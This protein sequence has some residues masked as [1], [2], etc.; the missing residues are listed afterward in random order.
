MGGLNVVSEKS[1]VQDFRNPVRVS[2]MLDAVGGLEGSGRPSKGSQRRNATDRSVLERQLARHSPATDDGARGEAPVEVRPFANLCRICERP[3][4]AVITGCGVVAS[5]GVGYDAF[6]SALAEG[7]SGIGE[8][9]SFDPS[10]TGRERAAEIPDFDEGEFLRSPKNYLDRSSALAFAACEMAV[11]QSGVSLPN[12]DAGHGVSVGSVSGNVESLSLFWNKV[13]EKGPK[14]APPFLFPHTYYNTTAGLLSIEYG[15][16]GPHQQFCSG[17]AGLEAVL[18]ASQCVE[19]RRA[20]L[21][22]AGGVEAFS[23]WLFRAALGRGWLSPRD[24]GAESCR[25]FG[26]KRNGTILGE[27]TA[28]FAIEPLHAAQQRGARILARVRGCGI[29]PSPR[30]AMSQALA[31]AAL[32]PGNV[33]AVFASAGGYVNED[34]REAQ[35]IKETFAGRPVP[36]VAIKGLTGETLGASGALNLAAALTALDRKSLPHLPLDNS[37]ILEELQLAT[38]PRQTPLRTVLINAGSPGGGRW[39][40][41]VLSG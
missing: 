16:S 25:P 23:E 11:R 18:F 40:S 6:G 12:R 1:L 28:F 15:L 8:I 37:D 3:Y 21:M 29:A 2:E 10:G 20:D 14:L 36:V 31:R 27:G 32:E 19:E 33:D 41:V 30:K 22:L 9:V 38:Q 4:L 13:R 34:A 5:N 7:R 35:A 26:R 17:A 39:L 24:D